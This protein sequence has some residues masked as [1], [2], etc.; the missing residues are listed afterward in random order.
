MNT[1]LTLDMLLETFARYNTVLSPWTW[2]IYFVGIATFLL[3][4]WP[5]LLR[6]RLVSAGLGILWLWVGIAFFIVS[7]A[8]VYPLAY[9][10]GALFIVQGL[11]FL[12]ASWRESLMFGF[13]AD[14]YGWFGLLLGVLAIVG[15]PVAGYLMGAQ[16]PQIAIVGAPC[17]AAI[18]T[19]GLLL[20]TRA[21]VPWPLLVIPTLWALSGI[22]PILAGMWPDVVLLAGGLAATALII[23]R[24][25]QRAPA[26]PKIR[27]AQ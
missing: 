12:Y 5:A 18:L 4:F 14:L 19:F 13:R 15:Y 20:M 23:Y 21:R 3:A 1:P 10:F 24:D 22:M 17:P 11:A 6:N 7:F 9:L 27:P 25:R 16:F 8:P 26:E 2:V